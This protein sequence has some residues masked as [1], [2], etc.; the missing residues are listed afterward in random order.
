MEELLKSIETYLKTR[1][2]ININEDD[3]DYTIADNYKPFFEMLEKSE[4]SIVAVFDYF[5]KNLFYIS[6]R[7]FRIFGFDKN[8]IMNLEHKYGRSLIHPDDAFVNEAGAI[9]LEYIG[10]QEGNNKKNYR[11]TG[12]FRMR[13]NDGQWMRITLQDLI[14]ETDKKGNPW[15]NLKLFDFS[16]ENDLEKSASCS[17]RNMESGEVIF[18]FDSNSFI[19][20]ISL[21][22][23]E[24]LDLMSGGY[25]SKEIA[26]KLYISVNTV[27]I[28]RKNI[29]EK[30][31]VSNSSEAIKAA[32]KLR[33]I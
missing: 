33:L 3:I 28:H 1:D 17:L 26:D 13:N 30:L 29:I 20:K 27:N 4:T 32:I 24:V 2:K 5:K 14:L 25:R 16:P 8:D 22:E 23:K 12:D 31:G 9:S 19:K 11:F 7:F 6:D 10:K 15:L 18:S 21:R